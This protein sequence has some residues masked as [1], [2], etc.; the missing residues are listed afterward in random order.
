MKNL[1]EPDISSISSTEDL[2]SNSMIISKL[3]LNEP[4]WFKGQTGL[5]VR[6]SGDQDNQCSIKMWQVCNKSDYT[7][8]VIELEHF[9][10]HWEA[11][12]K[13]TQQGKL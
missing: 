12:N 10:K 6:L 8:Y 4:T 2:I 11:M 13:N 1:N 3:Q 9:T 7:S 5:Q